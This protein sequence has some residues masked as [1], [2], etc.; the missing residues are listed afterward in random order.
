M[1][2]VRGLLV[3]ALLLASSLAF[4]HQPWE[5]E[6]QRAISSDTASLSEGAI[7]AWQIT[8]R[9]DGFSARAAYLT[10]SLPGR[11]QVEAVHR[12]SFERGPGQFT[13]VGHVLP[14]ETDVV[15]TVHDGLIAGLVYTNDEV[16]ELR[17]GSREFG[18]V[19]LALDQ[20][21]FPGCDG[22]FEPPV[23]FR[24]PERL[25]SP[26]TSAAGLRP[27]QTPVSSDTVVMDLIVFYTAAA[28]Q[29]QGGVSQI[30]AMAQAAVANA[31]TAFMNSNV[32]A[33][34]RVVL[35][36]ELAFS[37][38]TN[39]GSDLGAFRNNA[40]AQARRNEYHA[41]MVG[42]LIEPNYC[43]CGYVM[44]NPG[45]GFA[46][47]AFQVTGV[48]CAVG[49]LTYAHEHGHNM[50]MEHDPA[51]G[52][53][54]ANASYPWAFGHFQSNSFRTVMSYANQCTNCP[55]RM[56]FSNPNVS[57]QGNPTGI[58]NERDNARTA[59][60]TAPIIADFRTPPPG[61]PAI[62]VQPQS[63][64]W[65]TWAGNQSSSQTLTI[66]NTGEVAL[67]WQI[68]QS[69]ATNASGQS[70]SSL[71]ERFN[72]PPIVLQ[73]GGAA[74]NLSITAGVMNSGPVTGF[75]FEGNAV[76]AGGDWASDTRLV[77]SAPSGEN[78]NVGGYDNVVNNWAFQ[79]SQ[80]NGSGY[81]SS[82]HPDAFDEVDDAGTW[83][84][85]FTHGWDN[86]PN[87]LTWN[88]A[89]LTLHKSGEPQGCDA[90]ENIPWL[91]VSQTGGSTL[92]QSQTQVT[93]T[94][95]PTNLSSGLHT[96]WLCIDSNDPD[97]ARAV[98]PVTVEIEQRVDPIFD[99]R[100]GYLSLP[101]VWNNAA[102]HSW[103]M[104]R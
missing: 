56:Y 5:W 10:L 81:Y 77:L 58:A 11:G 57:F 30:E 80:S 4:A 70:R 82:A 102:L 73:G 6:P 18:P 96:A 87:T 14:D 52:T 26:S 38:T 95:N 91:T 9:T 15:L 19:L 17:A 34:F 13:W 68:T 76:V 12:R 67:E 37:E 27:L 39:C 59:R 69:A 51:N 47:S 16:F 79:G 89:V 64:N 32:D 92:P 72:L 23:D 3:L 61:Q 74:V 48:H 93:V 29:N 97:L 101:P 7:G 66:S 24:D 78:F 98:V 21:R 2:T 42:L 31:N 94:V 1:K 83:N 49:N 35:V 44:R 45:P 104:R 75:S 20:S 22:G 28:R 99:D 85:V 46:G 41:D 60:L 8:P 33:E 90:P 100:F 88:D 54:P 65:S 53:S 63:L 36:E 40:T 84:L 71:V 103:A 25:P 62:S 55:R 50:G 86:S 43:G